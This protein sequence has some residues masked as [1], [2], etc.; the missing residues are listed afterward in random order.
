MIEPGADGSVAQLCLIECEIAVGDH[1]PAVVPTTVNTAHLGFILRMEEKGYVDED[2]TTT[3]T[4]G[5]IF[6][7]FRALASDVNLP[8]ALALWSFLA[9]QYFGIRGVGAGANF[10]KYLG[11]GSHAI[12]KG[13]M[14][15]FVGIL[16]I[17]SEVGRVIS[18]TFRLFGNIFAGEVVLF[19]SMFLVA[20]V[21]PTVFFGLE[22]F[23]GFIQA[24]VFAM[25]TLVFASTA[26]GDHD[27]H[28]DEAAEH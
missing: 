26:V 19:I 14:G 15:V 18:F 12:V 27:E 11:V 22:V 6:P 28:H 8:L 5:H 1:E 2:G 21:V 23:V 24:F 20:F 4:V 16:E 10:G 17:V 7:I 3:G 13:P 25:L 9:V